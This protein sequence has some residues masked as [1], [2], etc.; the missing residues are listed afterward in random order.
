M[1]DTFLSLGVH[2]CVAVLKFN[3]IF[4]VLVR[5]TVNHTFTS[6]KNLA[7]IAADC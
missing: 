2:Q 5:F 1:L 6:S 7:L 3:L 4:L